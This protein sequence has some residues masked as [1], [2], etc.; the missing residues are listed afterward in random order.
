MKY[1]FDSHYSTHKRTH[2]RNAYPLSIVT[3]T[4]DIS[5]LYWRTSRHTDSFSTPRPLLKLRERNWIPGRIAEGEQRTLN[6]KLKYKRTVNWGK[7][8]KQGS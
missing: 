7:K 1:I 8:G 6:L 3:N 2:I 4:A 5:W